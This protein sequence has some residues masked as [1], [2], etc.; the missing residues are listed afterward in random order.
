KHPRDL[1]RVSTE[2]RESFGLVY[3]HLTPPA[4]LLLQTAAGLNPQRI[5]ARQLDSYLSRAV[6]WA[7][8][9][10]ADAL[11]VCLDR[12]L[13]RGSSETELT[14]HQLLTAYLTDTPLNDDV[15]IARQ[16]A[17]VRAQQRTDLLAAARAVIANPADSAHSTTLT[18]FNLSAP[19]WQTLAG[20]LTG[21]DLRGV[22]L[23][24][25]AIGQ[26][27]PARPWC[28]AAVAEARQ[29][30]AD[31]RVDHQTLGRGLHLVGFCYSQLGEYAQA[32]PFY[33]E[34]VEEKRQG[35][36][37]GRVDHESLGSC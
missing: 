15:G 24:L 18:S 16:V 11:E 34:A 2:A 33:E 7:E 9:D 36:A 8:R 10:T 30:D 6:D 27:A 31:G 26:F 21:D 1:A 35:D 17:T 12:Q 3:Q 13:L 28:E 23:A 22:G 37:D 4:Q 20:P 29:A 14:M 5:S 19:L 32:R 25:L